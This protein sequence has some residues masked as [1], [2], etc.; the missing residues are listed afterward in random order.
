[1]LFT[2]ACLLCMTTHQND[3]ETKTCI[4]ERGSGFS[5]ISLQELEVDEI[6]DALNSVE[7]KPCLMLA[8]RMSDFGI[9]KNLSGFYNLI[10]T[11]LQFQ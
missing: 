4:K 6:A 2:S 7:V 11:L 8:A 9:K 1:M 10:I 5:G 3:S